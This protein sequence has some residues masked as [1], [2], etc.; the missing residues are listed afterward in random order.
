MRKV[1]TL[2]LGM[3]I[4]L[5]L[6]GCATLAGAPPSAHL[7]NGSL[8]VHM[9]YVGQGDSIL[10]ISPEG[11][12]MLIDSGNP[13]EGPLEYLQSLGIERLD[14]VVATHWHGD[15]IGDMGRIISAIPATEV[16]TNGRK[17]PNPNVEPMMAAIEATGGKIR[18]VKRGDQ[19]KLGSLRFDVLH[20]L[21]AS[22]LRFDKVNNES[23]VLSLSYEGTRML[24]VGDAEVE[25]EEHMIT[26]GLDLDADIL[27]LGHHG[28]TTSSSP[29]FLAAVS[30][31]LALYSAGVNNDLGFPEPETIAKL[32]A[33]GVQILGT[34]QHG[35]LILTVDEQ[36][37][38]VTDLQGAVLTPDY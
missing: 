37:Y 11:R 34:D 4:V 14:M 30:P 9:I 15:H 21:A 26:S 35:T 32:Q 20:P 33:M 19:I 10:I 2:L 3:L 38:T 25:A 6:A 8:Q 28:A 24:F 7:A 29:A 12:T 23:V 36:G 27:K 31:E 22:E 13:N 16:I 17:S 1:Q 18:V 5:L